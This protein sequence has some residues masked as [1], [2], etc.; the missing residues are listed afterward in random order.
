MPTFIGL[1]IVFAGIFG[2]YVW[3]GGPLHVLVQPAELAIIGGA[4]TGTLLVAAPGRMRGRLFAALRKAF[5]NVAPTKSDYLELLQLQYEVFSFLRKH[6]AVQLDDHLRDVRASSIFRKYPSFLR[7]PL[8]VDFFRDALQQIVNGTASAEDLDVLLETE[9]DT[10]HEEAAIPV[11]LIQR[12]GDSLP[13]LGIVAAVLGIVIA[14]GSLDAS[15]KEIGHNVGAAL[16]GTFLGILL[17][18]GI[19][20][21][22]ATNLELQEVAN[23]RYLRCIKEGVVASLRGTAPIVVIEFARRVIFSDERPSA[24][25]AEAACRAVKAS[26]V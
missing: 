2:G 9:M 25:E 15:P 14:M 26:L 1:L 5:T 19:F 21:P 8:A 20:Q 13:G 7:R 22:M 10:Q 16:V 4:A 6:G 11:S 18:Y 12:T 23:G 24:A 3:A 17:C